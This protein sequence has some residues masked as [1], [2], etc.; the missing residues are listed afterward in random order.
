MS[1]HTLAGLLVR[2][3]LCL[4]VTVVMVGPFLWLV[5]MSVRHGSNV[6]E[7]RLIPSQMTLSTYAEAWSL[8]GIAGSF[9]NSTCV[10]VLAVALT[11]LLAGLAAYPL[12][13]FEFP[14]K[15]AVF[16]LFLSTLMVPFQIYMIPLYLLSRAAGLTDAAPDLPAWLDGLEPLAQRLRAYLAITLPFSV[17]AFG[18]YLLR[19]H[20]LGV[21]RDLEDA[22]RVDGAGELTIWWRVMMPLAKPAVATLAIFTFVAT[23]SSFLWPLLILNDERM[24]TLPV[25]LA[26]FTGVFGESTNTLAAASVI[27]IAPVI[28][29]FLLLQRWFIHG[30]TAGAVKG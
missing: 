3:T 29:F 28:V 7:L 1:P 8:G 9:L 30:I 14:G 23:W 17:S 18:V 5:S 4:L 22:A 6:Y 25:R 15:R 12:A 11:V 24:Y 16:V 2:Y 26:K 10:S 27:A 13:R 20:F 19:Q 21:P